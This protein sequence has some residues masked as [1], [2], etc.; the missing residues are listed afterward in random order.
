MARTSE[1]VE[2]V[3]FIL[4]ECARMSELIDRDGLKN[5]DRRDSM[6]EIPHPNSMGSMICG[7]KASQRLTLLSEE[8]AKRGGIALQVSSGLIRKELVARFV[9]WFL[10]ERR[11]VEARH[12]ERLM[13]TV[14]SSCRREFQRRTHYFPCHLT[15]T[16]LPTSI[17]VGPVT[18]HNRSSATGELLK[19]R[20]PVAKAKAMSLHERRLSAQAL[21]YYRNFR[22]LAE[23]NVSDCDKQTSDLLAEEAAT[24]AL[25][26]I[27]VLI[28]AP[29]TSRMQIGGMGVRHEKSAK[30]TI[31]ESGGLEP[32]V[33]LAYLGEVRFD[34][35]WAAGLEDD[36]GADFLTIFGTAL[37]SVVNPNLIRPLS[38][39]YLDAAQWFGE[40]ARDKHPAT[41]IVKYMTA[42]ERMLLP[43]KVE[44]IADVISNRIA[45]LCV[46]PD[47]TIDGTS[48]NEWRGRA[49]KAYDLRSKLVHGS[50]SPS[51][52]E[53]E[54]GVFNVAEL[55][56]LVLLRLLFLMGLDALKAEKVNE[57]EIHA[58][59]DQYVELQAT[60]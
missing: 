2:H 59:F 38:R 39:R 50:I 41:K 9:E 19:Q 34:D 47:R 23:V 1:L 15:Y 30:L 35:S 52:I 17:T 6:S 31:T 43:I 55:T 51:D 32:S 14:A 28:G 7:V 56:Q 48:F 4:S 25:D 57:K 49:K 36:V 58:W 16:K 11:P 53:V 24:R 12:V 40:A 13:A 42:L 33:S 44:K 54:N 3:E 45:A 46:C 29:W 27:H 37:E 8:S 10:K 5:F 22:W 26:G 21:K 20:L 60:A 18:F